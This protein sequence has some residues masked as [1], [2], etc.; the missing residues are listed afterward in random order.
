[1]PR[2]AVLAPLAVLLAVG[3]D[4]GSSGPA[5]PPPLAS[6][7]VSATSTT[8]AVTTRRQYT[9]VGYDAAGSVVSFTPAWDI[10][11]GGGSITSSGVVTAGTVPGTFSNTVRASLGNV[12]GFATMT[13]TPGAL[14]TI[15]VTP[16]ASAPQVSTTV[17]LTATGLDAY[18]NPVAITPAWSVV[19]GGGTIGGTTGLFIAG[20]LPGIFA[21]T[22]KAVS[23]A[24]SGFATIAVVAGPL[25]TITISPS[26]ATLATSATYQ[27]TAVGR[28]AS[29]NIVPLSVNW[30]VVNPAAGTIN[31]NGLFT[32]GTSVGTYAN[33]VRAASGATA[34]TATVTVT[35]V[36]AVLASITIT[37][38]PATVATFGT[39]QFTAF[40][41]D[42]A[43]VVIGIS[44]APVWTV[45]NGGGTIAGISGVFTAGGVAGAFT[46]TIRATS[47]T[48]SGFAST[49]V[50]NLPSVGPSF[51]RAETFAVLGS[52]AVTCTGASSIGGNVGVSSLPPLPAG[53]VSG[54]PAP[55]VIAAPG[56]PAPHVNDAPAAVAQ[57]DVTPA[58]LALAVMPCVTHLTGQDLGGMTLAPG[59][60]C[61][62]TSAQLTGNL[63]LSGPAN[64]LWVFQ[65][66]T[67]LTTGTS[68]QVILTGGAQ[69]KNV[70]WQIGASA[71][72][73]QTTIFRG[74][75]VAAVSVTMVQGSTLVGRALSKAAVTMDGA[76]ITLP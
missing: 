5:V 13:V 59:V 70:F 36:P 67:A 23:G 33:T 34:S 54:F 65:V 66:A 18:G 76:T 20:G 9:A 32:A 12:A 10:M 74:N 21:N 25:A 30:T 58:F 14:T 63:T 72:I 44:P 3:C 31:G 1:M 27:F 35:A 53:S 41:Q 22:V 62:A 49:T 60:Y 24:V 47:G 29:N 11:S 46:N 56:D 6:I 73:G 7:T 8:L 45:V 2:L 52:T 48:I 43:G 61:F 68:S 15:A 69:A 17:Q 51:G 64:G 4:S 39:Q 50:T 75:I 55:C 71:T 16:T 19:A 42:A 57:V 26:P 38:N 37:P 40:G 28:D